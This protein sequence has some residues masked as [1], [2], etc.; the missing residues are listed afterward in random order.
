MHRP[1]PRVQRH[2]AAHGRAR[3][4][5]RPPHYPN[6]TPPPP[7]SFS[8]KLHPRAS[9]LHLQRAMSPSRCLRAPQS[10]WMDSGRRPLV[11]G[12]LGPA[13]SHCGLW[14]T[15]NLPH[16]TAV[17]HVR[18]RC[19]PT[20]KRDWG[21]AAAQPSC[22]APLLHPTGSGGSS[23]AA[24]AVPAAGCVQAEGLPPLVCPSVL[25]ALRQPSLQAREHAARQPTGMAAA[26]APQ[27]GQRRPGKD[28]QYVRRELQG[29]RS[30]ELNLSWQAT[31]G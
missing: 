2:R 24:A 21:G 5:T 4:A 26:T 14:P 17:N 18:P 1:L 12:P 10:P 27:A 7:T 3:G 20:V 6:P 9:L 16:P 28:H 23:L 13:P 30:M 11:Y 25:H 8:Y 31:A 15:Y 22:L 19:L 29:S